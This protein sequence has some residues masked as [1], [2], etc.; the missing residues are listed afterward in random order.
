MKSILFAMKISF[1]VPAYNEE[2]SVE[3]SL[4]AILNEIKRA[5][6][7]AEVVLVNNASTDK[8]REVALSVE[9]V[10]VID[11]EKK[12][13]VHARNAGHMATS[14]ELV[15]NIDSDTRIPDGWLQTALEEFDRDPSLV[16]LSGPYVYHDLSRLVGVLVKLF[17]LPGYIFGPMIQ[18]GNFII[19]RDAWNRVGGYDTSIAFYGEDTDIARRLSSVGRVKWHWG[20][21]AYTSGRR[22]KAEG[23]LKTAWR[24]AINFLSV[25]LTRRPATNEYSDIRITGPE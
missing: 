23:L 9:G 11:E 25:H 19:R 21:C 7:D 4:R 8:T 1:V 24:Y 17:Y 20:L 16:A 18:G 22:I 5:G 14:G 6:A 3:S 13:L 10:R 15:A 2:A 12:G